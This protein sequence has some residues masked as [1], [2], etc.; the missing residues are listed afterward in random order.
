MLSSRRPAAV[1]VVTILLTC[2]LATVTPAQ[3]S[4][5]EPERQGGAAARGGGGGR[6]GG[7]RGGFDFPGR[8]RGQQVQGTAAIRGL[9]TSADTS[10][11]VRRAQIRATSPETRSARL[12]TTDA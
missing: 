1:V 11:P 4:G 5:G 2:T 9:V 3:R 6:G 10:S 8:G 12:G 7:G